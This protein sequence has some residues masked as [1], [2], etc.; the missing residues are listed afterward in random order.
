MTM[1]RPQTSPTITLRPAAAADQTTIR[2]MVR[3]G[4]V[5]MA[6]GSSGVAVKDAPRVAE[7]AFVANGSAVMVN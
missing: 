6:R 1:T 4:A 2:E 5:A 3:T 7:D